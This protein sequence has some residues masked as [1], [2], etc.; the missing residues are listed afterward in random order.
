MPEIKDN[1][2]LKCNNLV[3]ALDSRHQMNF[4]LNKTFKWETGKRKEI[5]KALSN[6]YK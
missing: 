4:F 1:N 5:F 6:I 2:K 3:M